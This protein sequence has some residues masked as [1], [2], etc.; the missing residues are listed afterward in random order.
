MWLRI[1]FLL[2]LS[3]CGFIDKKTWDP[4]FYEK[5]CFYHM[6]L[7]THKKECGYRLV[8]VNAATPEKPSATK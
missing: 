3:A 2:L 4:D 8:P 5:K 7:E 1:C 6:Y